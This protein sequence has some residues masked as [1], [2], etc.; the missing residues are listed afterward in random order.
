[1]KISRMPTISMYLYACGFAGCALLAVLHR[2]SPFFLSLFLILAAA[3]LVLALSTS[4]PQRQGPN[5]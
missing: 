3:V 4:F 1:M 2:K 5:Q